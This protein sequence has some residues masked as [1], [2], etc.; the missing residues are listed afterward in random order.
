MKRILVAAGL[1]A[2]AVAGASAEPATAP[3]T[4][5]SFTLDNGMQV[6][7][8]PDHRAP[9]VTHMVWYKVGAADEAPGKSGIAHLFEHVMFK[10]TKNIGPEEFTSIVQRS[11][12]QLNAFT[13]WDYTAY[14][15]RVHKDQLGK[16]MELE[17]ERMVNLIIN[18]DPKGPFI[19]ERDVVKEERRQRI[20]NSPGALL[21]E[22]VLN[23]FWKGH[24][25]EITVIGLMDE[26]AAL[27][28]QDGLD[29]Y[30]EYYS[31]ENA[32]LV[33]AGDVTEED[34]RVLAEEHYGPIEPTGQAHSARKWQPVAPLAET[35]LITH[36]DPKVRQ[37][38]WSRYYLGTS[39][40]RDP[41]TA[42]ALEVGLEVLGGGMTSRLYQSLVE[43]QKLA[44]NIATF[45]WTTLHDEGPAVIYGTPVSGVSL[46]DL[47][48][49]VMAE[50][51]K[52]LADG[53]TEAEVVRARNKLA[54][55]AIYQQDSQSSMA[56]HYGANLA[57][58]FTLEEIAAYPDEVRQVTPEQALAAVRAVFGAD[59]NYITSHLLP[60]EGDL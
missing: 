13:S 59:K 27:S 4:P 49:A 48:A 22:M 2:F 60:A 17:A 28:P 6:V 11:G 24:P 29:F 53:F 10:Q 25:Y 8:V 58:G 15:E 9:V 55:T 3:N 50:I 37:P 14:F 56:N 38:V 57:L 34:V 5:S 39:F 33:V 12:G 40:K 45:A 44:I 51:E 52:I 42:L 1:L 20:E 31:P 18:D 26:V 30:K 46:E 47:D 54:A 19:A 16:M 7:V 21:Q 43:Q 32:I 41:E 36:S 35:K 23:E